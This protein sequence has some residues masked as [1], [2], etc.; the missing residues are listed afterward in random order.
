M[1][2]RLAALLAC[3][4]PAASACG[5]GD[6]PLAATCTQS[7]A[8]IERALQRAPVTVRLRDG[9][10]L[11]ACFANAR[12]DAALQSFGIIAVGAAEHLGAR[13]QHGDARAAIQLGYLVGAARRGA[14]RASGTQAEL[15]R[16]VERAAAFVADGGAAA[17]L[18]L[19]RGMRAGEAGG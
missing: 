6:P 14:G 10:A 11:S 5:A 12:T 8:A 17:R 4:V 3:A 18:S 15:A 9:T 7:S 16:R 19:A 1:T 2:R 13:A